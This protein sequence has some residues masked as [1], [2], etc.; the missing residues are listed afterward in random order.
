MSKMEF[1]AEEDMSYLKKYEYLI[2]VKDN[3]G[4]SG[5]AEKLGISQ[6]TFSKYVKKIE[7]ELGI[8]LIDRSTLPVR[9]TRLVLIGGPFLRIIVRK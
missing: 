7:S 4:I 8:E 3:G 1:D 2:A 9:L 5:A 6:P